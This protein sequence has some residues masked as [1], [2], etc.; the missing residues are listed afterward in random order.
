MAK[1]NTRS[2]REAS[3]AAVIAQPTTELFLGLVGAIGTPLRWVSREMQREL[4]SYD[5]TV[6]EI[7]LSDFFKHLSWKRRLPDDPYDERTWAAMD[8]GNELRRTWQRDDALA[9]LAVGRI[10]DERIAEAKRRNVQFDPSVGPPAIDRRAYIIRSLKTPGE[11]RALRNIYGPRF[12]LIGAHCGEPTRIA[13]LR[14][15]IAERADGKDEAEWAHAPSQLIARDWNEE[16]EGGQ[17]VRGTFHE[18]DFF[19]DA[20]DRSTIRRDLRRILRVLFGYPYATPTREEY[21]M[22]EAAGAARRS[23]ELGRQVGAAIATRDGSIVAVGTNEVPAPGGGPYW[24]GDDSDHREFTKERDTNAE[25]RERMADEIERLIGGRFDR[26]ANRVARLSKTQAEKLRADL[27]AN[28]AK[29]VLRTSVGDVTEFGR[30]THAEMSALVD[31]ARRGVSVEGTTL[32]TTTFPC[33]NCA[34]HIIEAGITRVVFIEPYS[35]SKALELHADSM[36]LAAAQKGP[37]RS[38]KTRFEPFVG[39]APRRY[40]ELFDAHAREVWGHPKRKD[41]RGYTTDFTALKATANPVFSD[42]EQAELRPMVPI[43]R[44]RERRAIDLL[45]ELFDKT[46]LAVKEDVN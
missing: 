36:E 23:A 15:R 7:G 33:H 40:L 2:P 16:T 22:F 41:D 37:S 25:Y 14:R 34:R 9:L 12:F 29:D 19:I 20:H 42:L 46:K 35:K 31:A 21:A 1:R 18:A 13:N 45:Q 30:A 27:L 32:F 24:E 5:Y 26:A 39:V 4:A 43:Y 28:L 44:H 6:T 38:Q 10:E 3:G 8:A 11:L 17:D